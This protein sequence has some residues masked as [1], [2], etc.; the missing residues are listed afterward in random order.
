MC[1]SLLYIAIAASTEYRK[2][3]LKSKKQNRKKT[4]HLTVDSDAPIYNILCTSIIILFIGNRNLNAR[5]FYISITAADLIRRMQFQTTQRFFMYSDS[6][7]FFFFFISRLSGL[8]STGIQ[9]P[10]LSVLLGLLLY[11]VKTT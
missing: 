11:F 10:K 2:H 9:V 6:Y 5:R 8:L 7:T 4:Q 3:V 1:V